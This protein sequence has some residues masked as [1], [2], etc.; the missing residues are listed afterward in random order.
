MLPDQQETHMSNSSRSFAAA[1][2]L[3]DGM[4]AG[5]PVAERQLSLGGIRTAVLEGGSGPPMVLLHGPA[6]YA[7]HWAYVIPGLVATHRVIAPDLPGHGASSMHDSPLDV[8]RVMT[9]LGELI[10][11]TCDSPPVVIAQLQ[12]G[13]I[14]L[15]FAGNAGDRLRQLVLVDSFGLC[16]FQ[17]TP[18]FGHAV[19]QYLATP[20]QET[21]RGL[22]KHC[23]FDLDR[24]R[25]RM[26]SQWEP[27]ENYNL[28]RARA[29]GARNAVSVLMEL[30]AF[31]AISSDLLAR[32]IVPVSLI[33]GRHDRATPVSVAEQASARFG[34]PL[35]VIEDCADDPPIEQP[36]ATLRS[37]HAALGTAAEPGARRKA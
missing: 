15:R 36:E 22:W 8:E 23:A 11:R 14:A 2:S 30:F 7:A 32:I 6:A 35:H 12:S 25:D 9:W 26:G 3:R 29:P 24:L 19:A 37:L 28:D 18:E 33:W 34:W 31:P 5:L 20:T 10:D 27:F 1:T 13:A 4:L 17:P 21:H 16:P